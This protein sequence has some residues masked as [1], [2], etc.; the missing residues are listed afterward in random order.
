MASIGAFVE[1]L[2][3][4]NALANKFDRFPKRTMKEFGL[5]QTQINK[6]MSGSL[7]SLRTQIENDLNKKAL[8][9]RVKRG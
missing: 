2:A 8:V 3:N 4:D 5:T 7:A 1:A 9:F 6:I